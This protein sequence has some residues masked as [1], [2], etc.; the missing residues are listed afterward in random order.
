MTKAS[1]FPHFG[2]GIAKKR[3]TAAGTKNHIAAGRIA[4][5]MESANPA[6]QNMFRWRRYNVRIRKKVNGVSD[7]G[8]VAQAIV[9]AESVRKSAG[10]TFLFKP[11]SW[12][13]R[14]VRKT[15]PHSD[16]KFNVRYPPNGAKI[17]NRNGN[18]GLLHP[19][20]TAAHSNV[21]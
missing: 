6:P 12:P 17:A 5:A 16:R 3:N 19:G 18:P 20:C 21:P 15:V 14:K 1:S 2:R 13:N 10:K 11:N 8:T 4:V 9:P 7:N